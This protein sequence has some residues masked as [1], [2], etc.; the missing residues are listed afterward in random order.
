VEGPRI[1]GDVPKEGLV[2]RARHSIR[3]I[4]ATVVGIA[5]SL[6]SVAIAVAG[7][8]SSPFPK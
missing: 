5:M 8:G 6:A 7:D 1:C 3:V 2:F 4:A